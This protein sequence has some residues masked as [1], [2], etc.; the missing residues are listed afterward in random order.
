MWPNDPDGTATADTT[1]GMPPALEAAG[2]TLVFPGL[3]TQGTEDFSSL[4][5]K[6]KAE[7]CECLVGT[8]NP[9]DFANF[10]KQCVQQGFSPKATA[11]AR[12]ILTRPDMD[13][14]G[15]IA[16][17]LCLEVWWEKTW[18][19]TSPVTNLTCQGIVDAGTRQSRKP[20]TPAL[21]LTGG[22]G[23]EWST[24]S[25]VPPT[26]KTRSRTWMPSRPP[27]SKHIGSHQVQRPHRQLRSQPARGWPVDRQSRRLGTVCR[28]QFAQSGYREDGRYR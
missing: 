20:Y 24:F 9:P 2:Y 5:N 14:V 25:S 27:T 10:W 26:S 1:T 16:N 15:D 19:F 21:G 17:G 18:P 12:A 13:A 7:G 8:W 23:F 11:I 3:F 4:I 28:G 22:G 6:F